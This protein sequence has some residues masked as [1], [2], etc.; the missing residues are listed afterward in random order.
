MPG[1][2]FLRSLPQPFEE[3]VKLEPEEFAGFL[4]VFLNSRDDRN[5]QDQTD[6]FNSGAFLQSLR[7]ARQGLTEDEERAVIEAWAWLERE[8]FLAHTAGGA[9]FVTS[10][11]KRLK[12]H[13]EWEEGRRIDLLP[14][15][16]LHPFVS[17]AVWPSFL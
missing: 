15:K 10:R 5:G 6:Y 1:S 7:Q 17:A 8:G 3:L 2:R 13:T 12:G 4:L 14:R 11:G 16:L 9:Y